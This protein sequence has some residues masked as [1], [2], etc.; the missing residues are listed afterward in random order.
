[1]NKKRET[2][3]SLNSHGHECIMREATWL[4]TKEKLKSTQ[5]DESGISFWQ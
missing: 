1:M 2:Y 4:Q 5:G 3:F